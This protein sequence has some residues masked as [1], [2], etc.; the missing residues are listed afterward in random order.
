MKY[1]HILFR[2]ALIT[3]LLLLQS[4]LLSAQKGYGDFFNLSRRAATVLIPMT[5]ITD[6]LNN[7]TLTIKKSF[8]D[9]IYSLDRL[10]KDQQA[11]YYIHLELLVMD[12]TL[13]TEGTREL[14]DSVYAAINKLRIRNVYFH[15][16]K[17]LTLVAVQLKEAYQNHDLPL[18]NGIIFECSKFKQPFKALRDRDKK[19]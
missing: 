13:L 1:G 5:E 3:C 2:I 15:T 7:E 9:S 4:K 16:T 6:T 14:V 12:S 19:D 8:I 18:E 17:E 11:W 10:A